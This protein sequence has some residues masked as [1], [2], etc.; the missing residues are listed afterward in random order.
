[1]LLKC[2]DVSAAGVDMLTSMDTSAWTVEDH[3]RD[4]P[5][6]VVA[7]YRRFVELVQACGPFDYAVS[8]TAITFKGSRRG[9]AGAKPKAGSL[10]GYLD[11]QRRVEDPRIRRALPYTRRLVVHQ[12]RISAPEQLDEEFAGWVREAY[13]VGQ[14]EHLPR[15][16]GS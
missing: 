3:L 6:A 2:F 5:A 14:G 16:P 7:L 1:V 11:L 4:K 12:F 10:D 9:F 15:P 13:Q 8:K